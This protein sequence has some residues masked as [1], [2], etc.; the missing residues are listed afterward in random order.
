VLA[1]VIT[2]KTVK[3]IKHPGHDKKL[4]GRLMLWVLGLLLFYVIEKM[5]KASGTQVSNKE[6]VED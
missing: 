4:D 1:R 2:I 3:F 5:K 6:R